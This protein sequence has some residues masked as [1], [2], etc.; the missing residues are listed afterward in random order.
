MASSALPLIFP[1]INI[2][3]QYYGD[4]G[5][6]LA[7][8]LSP[9]LH[10]GAKRIL[11][12]STRYRSSLEEASEPK[13]VGYPPPAQVAGHLMNAIFLDLI[14]QDAMRLEMINTL[15]KQVPEENHGGLRKI[16]LLVFQH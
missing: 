15:I 5:I 2:D 11:A 12:M 7:A 8:P 10:L 16:D 6:R 13:T 9:A 14:D 3:D 4:G 1:A